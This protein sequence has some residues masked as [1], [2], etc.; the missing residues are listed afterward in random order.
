MIVLVVGA[1]GVLGRNVVPRLQERGHTV[2]A[3]GHVS[4]YYG[5]AG[6]PNEWNIGDRGGGTFAEVAEL[7]EAYAQEV[8]YVT[9][10]ITTRLPDLPLWSEQMTINAAAAP[11]CC[12]RAPTIPAFSPRSH[13]CRR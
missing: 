6:S 10:T 12:W 7:G 9:R 1:T 2:R 4:A 5:Q 3:I 11:G 8:A 13:R